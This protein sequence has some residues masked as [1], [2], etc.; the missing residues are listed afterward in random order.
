L[1]SRRGTLK[2]F[3]QRGL[4]DEMVGLGDK[5]RFDSLYGSGKL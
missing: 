4:A 5:G 2:L 1:A 3:E